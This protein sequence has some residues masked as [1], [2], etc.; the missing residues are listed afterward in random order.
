MKPKSI[1]W[2]TRPSDCKRFNFLVGRIGGIVGFTANPTRYDE[3]GGWILHCFLGNG[4]GDTEYRVDR[5]NL[6]AEADRLL[7][8]HIADLTEQI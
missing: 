6:E 4:G 5:S 2:T 7:V 3:T 1:I 8:E